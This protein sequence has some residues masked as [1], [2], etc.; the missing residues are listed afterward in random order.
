MTAEM[1]SRS[2][3]TELIS[4]Q[5]AGTGKQ[6]KILWCYHMVHI[7]FLGTERTVA[8][9]CASQVGRD[10]K[11]NSSAVT[12][13]RIALLFHK[14]PHVF[15]LFTLSCNFAELLAITQMVIFHRFDNLKE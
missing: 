5:V 7:A 9:A 2:H 15:L 14:V 1:M 4:C 12:A 10:V 3:G 8:L 11:P 13:P 6:S